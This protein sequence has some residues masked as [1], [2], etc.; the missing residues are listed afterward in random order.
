MQNR[1]RDSDPL[2]HSL[3]KLSQLNVARIGQA[4]ALQHG[5][6]LFRAI[7]CCNPG[8]LT[9][10]LQQ[11]ASRQIVI[12]IGLFRQESDLCLDP[13]IIGIHAQNAGRPGSREHQAHQQFQGRR[14]AGAVGA[15]KAEDFALFHREVKRS[16]SAFSTLTPETDPICLL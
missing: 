10:I 14:L 13:R 7:F 12:E 9:V 5:L 6:D 11:L 3:G 15:E 2:Q 8:E 1:L 16:Q 4:D